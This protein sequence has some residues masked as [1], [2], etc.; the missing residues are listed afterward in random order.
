MERLDAL[1]RSL[2]PPFVCCV[3]VQSQHNAACSHFQPIVHFEGLEVIATVQQSQ[4]QQ[5]ARPTFVTGTVLGMNPCLFATL[6]G[7]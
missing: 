7:N 6:P 5:P 3:N 1:V 2:N 4:F